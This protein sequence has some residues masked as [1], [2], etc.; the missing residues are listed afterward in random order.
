MF[1]RNQMPPSYCKLHGR[2]APSKAHD[3]AAFCLPRF[4]IQALAQPS[5]EPRRLNRPACIRGV[6]RCVRKRYA[7]VECSA[8]TCA[9]L[10]CTTLSS[11]AQ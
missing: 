7:F 11:M 5:S 1:S 8:G 2:Q 10:P 9:A 3:R 6:N 4:S